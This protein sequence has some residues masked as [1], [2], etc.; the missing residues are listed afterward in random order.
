MK[1]G[2]AWRVYSVVGKNDCV[3]THGTFEIAVDPTV[4]A[5]LW[6]FEFPDLR[7]VEKAFVATA[8]S[9]MRFVAFNAPSIGHAT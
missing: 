4:I 2:Y 1:S 7:A 5:I 3:R 6:Y 8:L 9:N